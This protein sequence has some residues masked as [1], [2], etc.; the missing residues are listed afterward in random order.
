MKHRELAWVVALVASLSAQDNEIFAQAESIKASELAS[1]STASASFSGEQGSLEA[2]Q[3]EQGPVGRSADD[4]RRNFLELLGAGRRNRNADM[5]LDDFNE[6]RRARRG[7]QG[8][9]NP[10]P[11]VHV[12]LRP[13]FKYPQL[14]AAKITASI[15]TRLSALLV[16]RNAGTVRVVVKDRKATLLGSVGNEYERALLAKL[17]AIEPGVSE[18]E[19]LITIEE[20]IALPVLEQAP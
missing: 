11:R 13:M 12:H 18:V 20:V 2:S 19:N 16:A 14:T 15:Q 8:Q 3:V 5:S 7:R 17:V 1:E 9:R 4:V 10:P 6:R